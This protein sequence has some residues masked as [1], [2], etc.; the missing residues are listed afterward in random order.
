MH[1]NTTVKIYR[2]ELQGLFF[3]PVAYIIITLFLVTSGWFFFSPYFFM[4]QV[5][6]RSFFHM[7][8]LIFTF[9]IPALTMKMFAEEYK[10]GSY[11]IL[12]TLPVTTLD[13]VLGKFFSVLVMV[14]IMIA[15]SIIY[16]IF[17]STTG[18]LDWGPVLGG[19]LGAFF[20]AST[21][22]AVGIYASSLTNNQI[23]AFLIAVSVN[24]FLYLIDKILIFLP[25][26]LTDFVQYLGS[27]Y[28]FNS[29][30]RGIIDSRD[31]VYFMSLSVI[32][33]YISWLIHKERG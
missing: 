14:L 21:Y 20:L 2:R 19:Y 17:V 31:I 33:L 11:E 13:V 32:A 7:L 30:S 18:P 1:L 5:S 6:M 29:F 25:A 23:I 8:P 15:P 9:T 22:S 16:A 4:N 10:S 27:V 24:F 26:F 28:H 3:S 12:M